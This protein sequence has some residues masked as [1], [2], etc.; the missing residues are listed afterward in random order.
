M[1]ILSRADGPH[2]SSTLQLRTAADDILAAA[3]QGFLS[4]GSTTTL[5]V[6]FLASALDPNLGENLKI[7]LIG[8]SNGNGQSDWD[9]VRLDATIQGNVPE[10]A[11]LALVGLGLAGLG[12][13]RR[14]K[15]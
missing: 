6:T 7:A 2:Q 5:T 1:D 9:N 10:P 3:T 11:S 14:K 12:F 8:G 13:S 4:G 15:A